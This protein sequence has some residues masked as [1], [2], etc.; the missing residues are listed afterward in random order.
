MISWDINSPN[1]FLIRGKI[2]TE[3][4]IFNGVKCWKIRLKFRRLPSRKRTV[5]GR[6]KMTKRLNILKSDCLNRNASF[7]SIILREFSL[8]LHFI[9]YKGPSLRLKLPF[10]A[11]EFLYFLKVRK[12]QILVTGGSMN[13]RKEDIPR[14][15]R[16]FNFFGLPL[17]LKMHFRNIKV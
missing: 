5:K 7:K 10:F 13:L 8:F 2:L 17:L 6:E 3:K 9:H 4:F 1:S 15:P 11:I 16:V 14:D 12:K